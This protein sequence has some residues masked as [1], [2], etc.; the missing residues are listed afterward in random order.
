MLSPRFYLHQLPVVK[1]VLIIVTLLSSQRFLLPYYYAWCCV[2]VFGIALFYFAKDKKMFYTLLI[3]SI[4]ISVDNSVAGSYQ[5]TPAV[6]RYIMYLTAIAAIIHRATLCPKR[7]AVCGLIIFVI[8]VMTSISWFNMR[9]IVFV[10]FRRDFLLIL[11]LTVVLAMHRKSL[12]K[13]DLDYDLL[14]LLLTVYILGELINIVFSYQPGKGYLSYDSLK[15]FIVFPFLY[16]LNYRKLRITALLYFVP[17]VVVIFSYQTRYIP[18][19]LAFTL[20]IYVSRKLIARFRPQYLL[21]ICF[22]CCIVDSI[23]QYRFCRYIQDFE[24]NF[25]RS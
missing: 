11:M 7:L 22:C 6:I 1:V 16:Y 5:L 9:P 12:K 24:Y 14:S 13:F 17:T 10:P 19:S 2:I 23:V 21:Y 20:M 25:H 4:F 8:L 18:L 15:S 3:L